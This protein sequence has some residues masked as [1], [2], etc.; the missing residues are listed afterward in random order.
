M[1]PLIATSQHSG[2]TVQGQDIIM[3][4]DRESCQTGGSDNDE[5]HTK[6][7]N[8]TTM[9][10]DVNYFECEEEDDDDDDQ[11][12]AMKYTN[13]PTIATSSTS[14]LPPPPPVILS[15][16]HQQANHSSMDIDQDMQTI[17]TR[18][19]SLASGTSHLY[20][21]TLPYPPLLLYTPF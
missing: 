12:V 1:V 5:Y 3:K 7:M 11:D 21:H 13:I 4:R 19:Y 16:N 20:V 10:R 2:M 14:Q 9:V 15:N 18:H 6:P 17:D 8:R